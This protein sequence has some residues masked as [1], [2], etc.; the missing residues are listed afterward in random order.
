MQNIGQRGWWTD[1]SM[2]HVDSDWTCSG[3]LTSEQWL[4]MQSSVYIW[5]VTRHVAV[6]LH[7]NSDWTCSSQ[8]TFEQWPDMQL[9]V[10]IWTVTRHAAVSLHLDYEWTYSS[11]FTSGQ[12]LDIQQSVYIWTMTGHAV[13]SLHLG[14]DWTCSHQFT[15]G[16][17]QAGS[18]FRLVGPQ[19]HGKCKWALCFRN[20]HP[21][22]IIHLWCIL[23]NRT[24]P[25]VL[26]QNQPTTELINA[27][28]TSHRHSSKDWSCL[29]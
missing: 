1:L 18:H 19:V 9:S 2:I 12:W 21:E 20:W 24:R 16:K 8:F 25:R 22:K 10:Y 23:W 29:R 26:V 28:K 4:D 13:I 3:Q 6:S 14:S 15:S 27:W 17:C 11:Q 7:L 5:T